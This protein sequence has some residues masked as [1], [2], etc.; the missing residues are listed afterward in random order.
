MIKSSENGVKFSI[1]YA[2]TYNF[3]RFNMSLLFIGKLL[4]ALGLCFQAY[5]LYSNP[6]VANTFNERLAIV[7]GS[8]NAI[9]SETKPLLLQHLRLVVVGLLACSALMVVVRSFLIKLFVLTGLVIL[10]LVPNHPLSK[11]PSFHD[12]AF[13]ESL[14]IIGGV[15]YLMGAESA[16][17]LRPKYKAE[18]SDLT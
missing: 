3:I 6:T 10:L 2:G 15:I 8:T 4:I 12:H 18:W 17:R 9:P 16:P 1:I 11:V 5:M 13:W 7:V 14:A